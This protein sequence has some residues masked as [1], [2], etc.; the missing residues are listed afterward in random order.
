[1]V[2]MLPTCPATEFADEGLVVG[3]LGRIPAI[4]TSGIGG[5]LWWRLPGMAI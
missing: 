5:A 2:A 1:M 3:K 4:L